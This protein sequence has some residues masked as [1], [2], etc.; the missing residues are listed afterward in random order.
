[1]KL[2]Q[3]ER[4]R[5]IWLDAFSCSG[6]YK[7]EDLIEKAKQNK[8]LQETVVFYVNEGYGYLCFVSTKN[9]NEEFAQWGHPIWI[10]RGCIKKIIKVVVPL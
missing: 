7:E 6:W 10:P 2:K 3:G 4:Y 9:P 5:I 1:M 8:E